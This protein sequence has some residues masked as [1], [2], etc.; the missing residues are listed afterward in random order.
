MDLDRGVDLLALLVEGNQLRGGVN[1]DEQGE[2]LLPFDLDLFG[3]GGGDVAIHLEHASRVVAADVLHVDPG[4][5]GAL[6]VALGHLLNPFAGNGT[7]IG[8]AAFNGDTEEFGLGC[9]GRSPWV[10]GKW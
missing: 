6:A 3:L 5:V 4:A 8:G 10:A 7:A 9:H 2:A 1:L